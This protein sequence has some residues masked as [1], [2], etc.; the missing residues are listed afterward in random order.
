M[1][2]FPPVAVV[3]WG[4]Y[5]WKTFLDRGYLFKEEATLVLLLKAFLNKLSSTMIS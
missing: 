2:T 1:R 5:E 3:N 4:G